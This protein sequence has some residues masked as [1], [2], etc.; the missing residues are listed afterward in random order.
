MEALFLCTY[1]AFCTAH[2]PDQQMHNIYNIW[3]IKYYIYMCVC[4]CVCVCCAFVGLDNKHGCITKYTK[5]CA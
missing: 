2:N 5:V 3:Y 4:V 1:R